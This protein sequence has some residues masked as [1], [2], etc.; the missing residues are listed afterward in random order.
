MKITCSIFIIVGLLFASNSWA[1]DKKPVPDPANR[2]VFF[3]EQHLHTTNSPD[4]FAMGARNTPDDAYNVA[5]GLAVK[6]NTTGE[7]VQK[8][9]AYD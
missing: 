3:G 1:L 2:K 4:A 5:K 9:T 8:K 7:M 6:K